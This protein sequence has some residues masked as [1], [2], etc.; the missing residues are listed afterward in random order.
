MSPS[1]ARRFPEASSKP[2]IFGVARAAATGTIARKGKI[3][4]AH[5]GT[6]FMDEIGELPLSAQAKAPRVSLQERAVTRVGSEE[7]R[8]KPCR[9]PHR[10]RDQPQPS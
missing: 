5:G 8:P 2:S 3:E 9:L 6:L 7:E 1:T 4:L 10:G